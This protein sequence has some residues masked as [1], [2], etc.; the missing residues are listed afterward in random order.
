MKNK[1]GGEYKF[2]RD[3]GLSIYKEEDREE[4]RRIARAFMLNDD[5]DDEDDDDE[6]EDEE[7]E[8][9]FLADIEADPS[10]HFADHNFSEAER[11]WVEKHYRHSGNFLACYGWKFFNDE[12]CKDAA[13]LVRSF[14]AEGEN[15]SN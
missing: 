11:D 13:A 6:D 14:M 3:Y 4:G 15:R 8:S 1:F 7:E 9:S 2:L 10:S 5:D 12:D